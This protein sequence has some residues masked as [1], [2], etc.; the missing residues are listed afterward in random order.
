MT[1]VSLT[2][3]IG[4][5]AVHR[6]WDSRVS[7]EE[8][9]AKFGSTSEAHEHDYR[10]GVTLSGPFDPATGLLLDLALLD[11]T[12]HEEIVA[13]FGGRH[14]NEEVP[15]FGAGRAQP[16][17]EALAHLIFARLL[18]RVPNGVRL[19]RVRVAEDDTLYADC[20][21]AE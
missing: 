15:E 14:L 13:R 6:L 11:R 10:C 18:R 8:N 9:R 16:T 1:R 20:T 21:A 17:C 19:E 12:L 7:A 5:R 2:R 4:F 3:T